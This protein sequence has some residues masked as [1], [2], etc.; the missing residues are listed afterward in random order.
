MTTPTA[1]KRQLRRTLRAR[2][3]A[4]SASRQ[5]RAAMSLQTVLAPH[6][7]L[8]RCRRTALYL[9]QDGELDPRPLARALLARNHQLFLPVIDP[10][11]HGGRLLRFARWRPGQTP[12]RPN[13]FGIPEPPGRRTPAWSLDLVLMPLVAFDRRGNRLGMGGGFYDRSFAADRQRPGRPL[14]VG[15]AH[16]FQEVSDLPTA[17]HDVPLDAIVTDQECLLFRRPD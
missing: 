13:R 16:A 2:R 14:L 6:P 4:L 5:R 17:P 10:I 9:P 1:D 11:R 7:L 15:L 8:L 12:L 3:Q